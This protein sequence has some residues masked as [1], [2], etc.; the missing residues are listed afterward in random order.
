MQATDKQISYIISLY[1]QIHGTTHG[2]L[3]QCKDLLLTQREKR[4]G[5]TK[6]EASAHIDALKKQASA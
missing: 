1:N 5:M 2:Y 6:A 4:G 3:S